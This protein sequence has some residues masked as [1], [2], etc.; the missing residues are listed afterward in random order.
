MLTAGLA[1][2]LVLQR[3]GADLSG[4]GMGLGV[5]VVVTGW[6]TYLSFTAESSIASSTAADKKTFKLDAIQ[7]L[8]KGG[9][10][11]EGTK[12]YIWQE[13]RGTV[14]K[15]ARWTQ[16]YLPQTKRLAGRGDTLVTFKKVEP[17]ASVGVEYG[18]RGDSVRISMDLTEIRNLPGRKR[19]YILN[20][21]DALEFPLYQDST[22]KK[23]EGGDIGGW[24]KVKASSASLSAVDGGMSFR[25][26]QQPGAG[27]YRGREYIDG[28]LS[29]A[30]LIYDVTRFPDDVFSYT[31]HL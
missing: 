31:V 9:R 5:P 29:W 25:L 14:Y 22:G 28:E 3:D 23:L 21:H 27:L 20:E 1:K 13:A 30:G 18:R 2:G 4:E 19:I 24:R 7:Q 12:D 16:K 15:T 17:L 11:V 8:V 6:R 26:E 10:E